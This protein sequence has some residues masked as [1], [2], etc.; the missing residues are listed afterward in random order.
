MRT[1]R[2]IRALLVSL[3]M[4][5]IP[6]GYVFLSASAADAYGLHLPGATGTVAPRAVQA[7]PV[8]VVLTFEGLRDLEPILNFY[9]GGFGGGGS[10]PGPNFG[11][12]FG[13]ASLAI[14][15]AD[16]GGT[17][18]F[19]NEPTPDT[20]AFFLT[21]SV[22]MNV[23][24]GFDTGFSFFYT[25]VS[26]AGSV[27]VWD[28][29]DATGVLLGTLDLVPNGSGCGGDPNGAFNCWTAVGV[30]FAGLARSVDF[31][32]V[33]NQIGFDNITLGSQEPR[34]GVPEPSTIL[35]FA[36]GFLGLFGSRHLRKTKVLAAY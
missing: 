30:P 21:G 22:I 13:G 32:G 36:T 34:P 5:V 7:Q 23:P 33:A 27:R 10:G 29:P 2:V 17:G 1:S 15:D 19:A 6:L 25:S 4:I 14:I 20:I 24:A 11:I 18:N 16:A 35:L 12:V 26:F 9:N 8:V 31:G 28:G 3:L